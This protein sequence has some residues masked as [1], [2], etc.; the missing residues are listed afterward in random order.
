MCSSF[1]L[2]CVYVCVRSFFVV[3][4]GSIGANNRKPHGKRNAGKHSI[5][6]FNQHPGYDIWK[7]RTATERGEGANPA[8]GSRW[9]LDRE[10]D[11][12]AN[13][14]KLQRKAAA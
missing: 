5:Y 12:Q 3:P 2:L 1:H 11:R 9:K 10:I 7:N 14:R 4:G 6:I 13:M 8:L